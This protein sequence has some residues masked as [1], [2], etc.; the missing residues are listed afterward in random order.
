M[1]KI[2]WQE[3]F[4]VGIPS[5]DNQHKKLVSMINQLEDSLTAGKGLVNDDVGKVL[6]K[7]VEYT[8]FHFED[9]EKIQNDIQ[10]SDRNRHK[11]L[12]KELVG[13]VIGILMK[14]KKGETINVFEMMNF[15][16]DW[17]VNH[18]LKEDRKI[19]TAYKQFNK[20]NGNAKLS[21]TT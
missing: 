15:L 6:T 8:K 2:Q 11:Q 12:H 1:A 20:T 21:Q 18:I 14:L 19:G 5:V 17:L 7:L 10:Y 16:R 3:M 13:Q 4:S 9:E